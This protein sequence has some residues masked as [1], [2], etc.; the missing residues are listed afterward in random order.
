MSMQYGDYKAG[1]I[2]S[3]SKRIGVP[4]EVY[5]NKIA[6]G[7]K[8]CC[9]CKEWKIKEGNFSKNVNRGDGLN[10]NCRDCT[11]KQHRDRRER[12]KEAMKQ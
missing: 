1:A 12:K 4:V 11:K 3:A 9:R 7:L 5:K 2:K 6:Q 10:N 8:W